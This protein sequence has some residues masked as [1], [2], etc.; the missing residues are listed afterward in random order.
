[1]QNLPIFTKESLKNKLIEIRNFGW[2]PNKR[3][4]NAGGA[5]NTLEDLLGI[6]ENNLPLPNAGEWELKTRK[7]NST[8]LITLF[9]MEPSP[10]AFKF[11]PRILLPEYGWP[12]SEAGKRY[13]TNEKSF[14]QT[15][16]AQNRSDRGFT[17]QIDEN[18]NRLVVSFDCKRYHL[19]NL[20]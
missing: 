8:S 14:R 17:I 5:G 15:I 16:N 19:N 1:M 11:V 13:N 20:G 18:N 2:V 3:T 4:G 6:P 7:I 12:H 10:R 9:H